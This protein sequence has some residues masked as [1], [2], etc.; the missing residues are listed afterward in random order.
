MKG[1]NFFHDAFCGVALVPQSVTNTSAVGVTIKEPWTRGRQ[2]AFLLMGGAQAATVDGKMEIQGLQRDDGTTWATLKEYDGS[3]DL[4]FTV[5]LLD[6]AGDFENGLVLGT[7]PLSHVD[8]ETYSAIRVKY[9]EGGNAASLICVGYV[10]Y[11]LFEKPS[12]MT[13]D[14]FSKCRYAS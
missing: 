13:D 3:T 2:I 14:L 5:T 9:T 10:I 4:E 1:N 7:I 12:G 11:D 8:S 6:D